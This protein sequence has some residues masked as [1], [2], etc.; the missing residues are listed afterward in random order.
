MHAIDYTPS[1]P[2]KRLD[3]TYY[4]GKFL[5][6][7]NTFKKTVLGALFLACASS[8]EALAENANLKDSTWAN[9]H[10]KMLPYEECSIINYPANALEALFGGDNSRFNYF[11]GSAL[12]N[13]GNYFL[14]CNS[15]TLGLGFAIPIEENS[16][17]SWGI[18][19]R[20]LI[21]LASDCNLKVK[22]LNGKKVSD[23]FGRYA[24]IGIG[25][26]PLIYGYSGKVLWNKHGVRI[27][28]NCR[29]WGPFPG[30]N[31]DVPTVKINRVDSESL[32][33]ITQPR[34]SWSTQPRGSWS[35][36]ESS[37]S[38]IEDFQFLKIQ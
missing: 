18:E 24:G 12:E 9:E 35:M 6:F 27:Q 26:T 17:V 31:L 29:D 19:A 14:A 34:G 21:D 38:E 30:A 7:M 1:R 8:P 4:K 13:S 23:L 33:A 22:A 28:A 11:F 37:Y 25:V 16:F 15:N 32:K 5:I 3:L 2:V 36:V 20:F 10:P